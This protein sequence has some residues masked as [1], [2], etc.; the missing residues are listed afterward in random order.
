MNFYVALA[1]VVALA[2]ACQLRG[3]ASIGDEERDPH[4]SG[5]QPEEVRRRYPSKS[6]D[7]GARFTLL[8]GRGFRG[9]LFGVR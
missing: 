1:L 2:G 8:G 3:N 9:T 6:H 5:G 7:S 4:D